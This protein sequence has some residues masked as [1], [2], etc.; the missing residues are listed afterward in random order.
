M[1]LNYVFI[2]FFGIAFLMALYK[3]FIEGVDIFSL[4]VQRTFYDAELGAEI[5]I[6][7]IGVFTLWMGIM[8]IGEKGGAIRILSK[9]VA[10]FFNRIFPELPKNHP[11]F[12]SMI[13]NFSANMLGLD[14]AATPM[15]LKAIKELQD[16]NPKKE[17]ASNAQIMFLVLNTSGLTLIPIS[18]LALRFKKL[19]DNAE[20]FEGIPLLSNSTDVFV[21]ILITTFFSSLVGIITVSLFQKINLLKPV[22]LAYLGTLSLII[23]GII[24]HFNDLPQGQ[25]QA[26]STLLAGLILMSFIIGF[27]ALA[28]KNKINVYHSF[29]EGAKEGFESSIKI[30]P[31]LVGI[32]VAIGLFRE[33]GA[34]D[35]L[36]NGIRFVVSLFTD[37]TDFVDAMPTA[38][39]KPLSGGGARAA[40]IETMDAYPLKESGGF[41]VES[42]P[43]F[44]SGVFQGSTETTFYVLAVYFGSVGIKNTRYALG[45]GLIADL[46]GIIA[47]IVISYIFYAY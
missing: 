2:G 42:F 7:F 37:S 35:L 39:M 33:C 22:V 24:W 47:A 29:L 23:S 26:Q 41:L 10:P 6:G 46:A 30:I 44:L 45:A 25:V 36:L 40:M 17:R 28:V 32:L 31:Y 19:S 12:G 1:A 18:I 4:L 13:M 11:V 34:L 27:I 14:N 43:S 38:I 5:C 20:A 3:Y 9:I 21:P 8:K 16:L 15:G